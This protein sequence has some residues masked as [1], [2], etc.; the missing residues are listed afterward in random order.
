MQ[1]SASQR[2]AHHG[3]EAPRTGTRGRVSIA[4]AVIVGSLALSA[5]G[6]S[7][8]GSQQASA[9]TQAPQSGGALTYAVDKTQ[10]TLDPAVSA[11]SVTA[12]IDRNIFDSL[13]VQTGPSSFGPWLAT[14]WTTSPDGKTY[15]FHLRR[16]VTFHDGTPFTAAAVKASLDHVV[17]PKTASQYAASLLPTYEGSK[18]IAPDQVQIRLSAPFRPLL[19]AL[20]TAYLGIQSPK[21]LALPVGKYAPV[22]TGPFKYGSWVNK[23]NVTL[24]RAASYAS[25]PSNAKHTGA[26]Y[27]DRL[28]FQ[29][30]S[31]DQT[32][33]GALT[34]NQVQGIAAV[35]PSDVASLKSSSSAQVLSVPQPG[36]SY[37]LYFQVKSGPLADV[38]VRKALSAAIDVKT[39]IKTVYF[40]QFPAA[41]NPLGPTTAY[42]D[43]SAGQELQ[44]FDL[45][46]AKRLLDEA[47][48]TTVNSSGYR[49]K[50]GKQLT[51]EWPT[52]AV[53]ESASDNTLGQGIVANAK[54]AGIDLRRPSLDVGAYIDAVK[55]T[56]YSVID[57]GGGRADPDILRFLYG[58][59]QT[60]LT[61]GGN[62]SLVASPQLDGWL[63]DG[64]VSSEPTKLA[65]DYSAAQKYILSNAFQLPLHDNVSIAGFSKTVKGVA[66]DVSG[67]PLFYSAW[68]DD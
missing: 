1:L 35:P 27:L 21:A 14:R 58:A 13:V 54:A 33:Y 44:G 16:G 11:Q 5:C 19:Q 60:F 68:L 8:S 4:A 52:L 10:L 50:D 63:N 41:T 40:G 18:V 9:T 64:L 22:G 32:R 65:A 34:S 15:T 26:A 30:I 7:Q 53:N 6:S 48:W 56:K 36:N 3:R 59:K 43:A 31:E 12:L 42:H 23:K 28:N 38:R 17:D 24:N 45:A 55:K 39:L 49:T 47:G 57:A 25:A 29:L 66:S 46:T 67:Y 62:T 61:G 20:S 2:S 37:S 51:V